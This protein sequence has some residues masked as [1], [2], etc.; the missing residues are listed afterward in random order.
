MAIIRPPRQ[1]QAYAAP[2]ADNCCVVQHRLTAQDC[3]VVPKGRS[4]D[5]TRCIMGPGVIEY[6][7]VPGSCTV[8][9]IMG[10]TYST[11]SRMVP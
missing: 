7:I 1:G 5:K 8:A 11:Y 2:G 9:I 10:C 6:T 3:A 4:V